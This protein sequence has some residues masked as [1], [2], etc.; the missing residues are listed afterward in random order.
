ME[1]YRDTLDTTLPEEEIMPYID[2]VDTEQGIDDLKS[3][4]MPEIAIGVKVEF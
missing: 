2:L 4:K 3:G 1:D